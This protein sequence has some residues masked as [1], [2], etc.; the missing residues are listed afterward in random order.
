LGKPPKDD[1]LRVTT[2]RHLLWLRHTR[3]SQDMAS[4]FG[5]AS[6]PRIVLHLFPENTLQTLRGKLVWSMLYS[7]KQSDLSIKMLA[8]GMK[9]E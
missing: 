8:L 9:K 7:N 5:H 1:N 2:M 4:R 3:S 6:K